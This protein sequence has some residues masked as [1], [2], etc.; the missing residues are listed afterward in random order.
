MIIIKKT[1]LAIGI[2]ALFLLTAIIQVGAEQT[3]NVILNE[4]QSQTDMGN[5]PILSIGF[6][7]ISLEH[8]DNPEIKGF[9]IKSDEDISIYLGATITG[10]AKDIDGE[11]N[12]VRAY[13][14]RKGYSYEDG[15][16]I[17][18]KCT[19][20]QKWDMYP[21]DSVFGLAINI[22]VFE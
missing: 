10:I 20:L 22:R 2:V 11:P 17:Y 14:T 7:H 15:E 13:L 12:S 1:L 5:G 19:L 16:P 8:V 6:G 4:N 3:N 21:E 9:K 18:I